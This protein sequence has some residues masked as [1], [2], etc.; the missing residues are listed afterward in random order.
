MASDNKM[1]RW[2]AISYVMGNI[3]GAGIF[4]AP[5]AIS[6]Q[7]GSAGMSIIIWVLSAVI[8]TIGGFC[9]LELGTIV[10]RSGGDFAYL[11]FAFDCLHVYGLWLR[12]RLSHA[13]LFSMQLAIAASASGE[14]I[15]QA[16]QFCKQFIHCYSQGL[17]FSDNPH[18]YWLNKLFG[19]SI[20]WL[21][22]FLNFFSI[23]RVGAPFQM[24]SSVAKLTA[25]TFV[26]GAGVF[27]VF[28]KGY[29]VLSRLY[30]HFPGSKFKQIDD[31]FV[32]SSFSAGQI[33][34]ALLGGFY[35]YDGWDILN[36]GVEEIKSPERVMPFAIIGGMSLVALLYTSMNCAYFTLLTADEMKVSNA[37]AMT[38][39]ER[40]IG[41]SLANWTVPLLINLVL[42]GSINGTMFIASRYL[43][44]ASR[45][46]H[47]PAFLACVNEKNES[48]RS[49]LLVHVLLAFIFSFA[50]NIEQLIVSMGFAQLLQRCFTL[51][52]LLYIRFYRLGL[53][54]EDNEI[55]KTPIILPILFLI[56]CIVLVSI[57]I[58]Q[59]FSDAYIALIVLAFA[60]II[61]LLFL[62][63]KGL[64]RFEFYRIMS[65]QVNAS[66]CCIAQIIFNG[67]IEVIG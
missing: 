51:S 10:K 15:V 22:L 13:A 54:T 6:N 29:S 8:C 63:D 49:A 26:I 3:V 66:F 9:Y 17:G 28:S 7:V 56:I 57:I 21:I 19:F 62:W 39:I 65:E 36:W 32:N 53:N 59:K 37:V 47:L 12:D 24:L 2:G 46:R 41:Q 11:C 38:F 25:C 5:T 61:Y 34:A 50:G 67:K 52:A 64:R 31:F 1:G 43:F 30:S 4:I 16:F 33:S 42:L 40:I 58:L 20:V 14:Y 23:R 60:A 48:P 45:E 18:V 55:I 44:A 27:Q 35:S